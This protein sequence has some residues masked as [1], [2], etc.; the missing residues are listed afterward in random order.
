MFIL[1]NYQP[2]FISPAD[3]SIVIVFVTNS[4][5]MDETKWLTS[6]LVLRKSKLIIE[7]DKT[8]VKSYNSITQERN[9]FTYQTLC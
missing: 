7:E 3:S 9:T 1:S 4:I 8:G 2:E 5:S 6:R